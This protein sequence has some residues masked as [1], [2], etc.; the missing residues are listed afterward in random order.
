M[1]PLYQDQEEEYNVYVKQI[2]PDDA[3]VLLGAEEIP[4][5]ILSIFTNF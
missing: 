5:H 3:V 4:V 1:H 2:I